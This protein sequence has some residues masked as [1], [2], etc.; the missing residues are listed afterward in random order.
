MQTGTGKVT[1]F[2]SGTPAR[3]VVG[4]THWKWLQRQTFVGLAHTTPGGYP[5][6]DLHTSWYSRSSTCSRYPAH[7]PRLAQVSTMSKH[8]PSSP[9]VW[10]MR[11]HPHH[12]KKRLATLPLLQQPRTIP[13][14]QSLSQLQAMF[15][16]PPPP[17][18]RTLSLSNPEQ[19]RCHQVEHEPMDLTPGR[20]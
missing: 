2:T 14:T 3:R 18:L 20:D 17:T 8:R 1:P 10:E 15:P 12:P 11:S 19:H 6:P 4:I 13:S 9:E 16:E 5:E 7:P